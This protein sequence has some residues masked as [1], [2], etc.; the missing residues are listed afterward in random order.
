MAQINRW[1]WTLHLTTDQHG[2]PE[3]AWLSVEDEECMPL[4][5][6]D[7]EFGPFDSLLDVCR[8]LSGNIRRHRNVPTP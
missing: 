4:W 6:A 7:Q 2:A 5:V 1:E 8:W 3:F